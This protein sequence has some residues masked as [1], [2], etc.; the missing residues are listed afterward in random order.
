MMAELKVLDEGGFELSLPLENDKQ[1][2]RVALN[3]KFLKHFHQLVM[4]IL[5]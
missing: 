4:V 2:L 5:I 1:F 3:G